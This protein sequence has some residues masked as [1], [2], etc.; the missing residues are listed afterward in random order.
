M[1]I[2]IIFLEVLLILCIG[3]FRSGEC[4]KCKCSEV[5]SWKDFKQLKRVERD[6]EVPSWKDFKPLKRVERACYL[7]I[8]RK[9]DD[10]NELEYLKT[11]RF[12]ALERLYGNSFEDF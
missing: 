12:R 7:F 10:T 2:G 4:R 6:S 11:R 3:Y 8:C 5:P 9:N 1:K